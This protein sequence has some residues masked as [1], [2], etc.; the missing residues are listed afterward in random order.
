MKLHEA[1]TSAWMRRYVYTLS[2]PPSQHLACSL[3]RVVL[4]ATMAFTACRS[5]CFTLTASGPIKTGNCASR[6]D[7]RPVKN[8]RRRRGW[9]IKVHGIGLA[10]LANVASGPPLS[11]SGLQSRIGLRMPLPKRVALQ[12]EGSASSPQILEASLCNVKGKCLM[13]EILGVSA[14]ALVELQEIDA[15]GDNITWCV[16]SSTLMTLP[17]GACVS[18]RDITPCSEAP[19]T[20]TGADGMKNLKMQSSE[21]DPG[22]VVYNGVGGLQLEGYPRDV[23]GISCTFTVW[24]C[25]GASGSCTVVEDGED[26][27][28]LVCEFGPDCIK[29]GLKGMLPGETRRFWIPAEI[30]DRRF[31]RPPPDRYLPGGCVVVD[32]TLHSITR[33]AVFTYNMSKE[34]FEFSMEKERLP[35]RI[36]LR[37]IGVCVQFLPFA[38]YIQQQQAGDTFDNLK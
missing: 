2:R 7:S 25:T 18:L 12:L 16:C 29:E 22:S 26:S 20:A 23:D 34:A 36:L 33:E 17:E 1:R 14:D 13:I 6:G 8:V 3:W 11:S 19:S 5:L 31:G 37:A 24:C 9:R 30:E 32:V 35:G 4:L 28:A 27:D 38:W 15:K 10:E 21:A